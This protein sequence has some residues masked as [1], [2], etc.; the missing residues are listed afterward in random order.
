MDIISKIKEKKE[1]SSLSD[2]F[3]NSILS[4]LKEKNSKLIIKKAR[5]EL[6]RLYGGFQIKNAIK[7]RTDYLKKIL[8]NLQK[9]KFN[10]ESHKNLLKTH[11]S[12]KER[13]DIYKDLYK[14]IFQNNFNSIQDIACGLNPFSLIFLKRLNIKYYAYDLDC[15]EL[16]LVKEYFKTIKE[17]FKEFDFE[18]HPINL[19]EEIPKIKTDYCF[20]FKFFDL[21]ETKKQYKI[22][23]N[24]IKEI[25]SK[26]IIASFS[27]KT[28]SGKLMN[29]PNRKWFE[30]MLKRLNFN[31]KTLKY[32]N[33]IFYLVE[34]IKAC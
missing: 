9:N 34:K 33:E 3:V 15:Q 23:E 28:L 14:K 5:K 2:S 16:N 13:L 21:L 22:A 25:N 29:Y 27:T 6:R 11:R 17:N 19:L 20:L 24:I 10:L 32:E 18:V 8:I 4:Q 12:T 26:Y 31:F 7:K 1:L 30:L